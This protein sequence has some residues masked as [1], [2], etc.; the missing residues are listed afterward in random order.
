MRNTGWT[1]ISDVRRSADGTTLAARSVGTALR[2]EHLEHAPDRVGGAG[3]VEGDPHRV[4]VDAPQVHAVLGRSRS[5]TSSAAT[6]DPHRERVEERRVHE[7]EAN[8][9]DRGGEQA[10]EVVHPRGDRAQAV[11][12][13]VHG[14]HARDVR[15]QHLRGADVAGG[16]LAADVLLTGLERQPQ[17]GSPGGVDRHAH[18]PAR[19]VAPVLVAGREVARACGP[20]YP[21][22]TPKRCAE[23]TTTSSPTPPVG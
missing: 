10:G 18:E 2:V 12:A 9:L 16:L 7:L 20:P 23:P 21:I 19:H 13:V 6:G 14:V 15:Q 5:T 4:G 8:A 11:G 1:R 22:G 17:R 3:L